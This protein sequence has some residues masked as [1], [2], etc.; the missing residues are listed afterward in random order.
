VRVCC[1]VEYVG[2]GKLQEEPLTSRKLT[3]H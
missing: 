3:L 2:G 1:R